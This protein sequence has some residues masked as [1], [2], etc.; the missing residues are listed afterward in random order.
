MSIF[1]ELWLLLVF[2]LYREVG[3]YD[4]FL[5]GLDDTVFPK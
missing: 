2:I 4:I 5:G 3:L 1:Y